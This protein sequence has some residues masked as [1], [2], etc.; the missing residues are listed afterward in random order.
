MH[1][2]IIFVYL[3]QC[4]SVNVFIPAATQE[5]YSSSVTNGESI[6]ILDS[7]LTGVTSVNLDCINS[8]SEIWRF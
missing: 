1:F 5:E 2:L 3:S 7:R 8:C 6:L 4:A